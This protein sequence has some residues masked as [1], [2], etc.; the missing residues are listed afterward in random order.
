MTYDPHKEVADLRIKLRKCESQLE[1]AIELLSA[2]YGEDHVNAVLAIEAPPDYRDPD[3]WSDIILSVT[4]NHVMPDD[5]ILRS[6]RRHFPSDGNAEEITV[7]VIRKVAPGW[8]EHW[9]VSG[10]YFAS[11]GK[12]R[13]GIT[14]MSCSVEQ[15]NYI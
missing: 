14:A 7:E 10:L 6:V 9:D 4:E 8:W 13:V 12:P 1:A 3:L 11:G 5:L 15:A 2:S